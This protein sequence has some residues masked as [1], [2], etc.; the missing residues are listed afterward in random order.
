MKTRMKSESGGQA[1]AVVAEPDLKPKTSGNSGD[2]GNGRASDAVKSANNDASRN[3]P[4]AS[5]MTAQRKSQIER[6]ARELLE[7]PGFFKSLRRVLR[8][9]RLVGELRNALVLYVVGLSA[10]LDR[11]LNA[12]VKGSSSTGKNHL[13]SRTLR[14]FPKE[15]VRE[16]TSSSKTAW[17]Y[18]GDDF[19]HAI[20]YLQ[21]R[22]DAAGAVHPVRLL[23]SEQQLIRTVTVNEGG[24]RVSKTFVAEGP[25]AS[26]S[27]TTRD[28]IKVDDE[29]RHISLWMDESQEQ[30]RKIN[31]SYVLPKPLL[32]EDE[33]AVWHEAYALIK[34]RADVPVT[35]PGWFKIIANNV[36]NGSVTSRRYFPN[37]VEGCRT[38]ALLRSFEKYPGDQQPDKIEVDFSDFAIATVLFEEVFVESLDRDGD[39]HLKTRMAVQEISDAMDGKP[40]N[41]EELA[42]R[43][44]IS[45][46]RAYK[47]MR[48][49]F[50]TGLIQRANEPQKGNPKTYL[51]A[52]R[53]RFIPD[54][55]E[56]LQ[57]VPEVTAPVEFIDPL[58][59]ET[60][61]LRRKIAK[62]V[63]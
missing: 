39:E 14:L 56:I 15:A 63:S 37:F 7:S 19:R 48:D 40:V 41:A 3:L 58:T 50:D 52:P 60:V 10:L 16:I 18:G 28:R 5:E 24:A 31:E 43:M 25:I 35:L 55:A 59:D 33:V 46:D 32:T 1:T 2:R 47:L 34:A 21:E 13:V 61:T 17:N 23:I 49:A 30:T 26:I 42:E 12:I 57:Q 6:G 45:K 4:A 53:P 22:N 8:R 54:P 11:P 9:S 62:K 20:V 38:I 27:T 36:F 29:N 44:S 51:P